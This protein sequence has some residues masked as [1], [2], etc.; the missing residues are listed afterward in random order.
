MHVLL[1]HFVIVTCI[2]IC[3]CICAC[4]IFSFCHLGVYLYL[5]LCMFHFVTGS[6]IWTAGCKA[7]APSSLSQRHWQAAKK[8]HHQQNIKIDRYL[9]RFDICFIR[10]RLTQVFSSLSFEIFHTI[11]FE[12]HTFYFPIFQ[13]KINH[14]KQNTYKCQTKRN[15]ALKKAGVWPHFEKVEL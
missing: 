13:N 11:Y 2:C 12:I 4:S 3:F 6:G 5:Y 14:T 7:A 1:C 9:Y 10:L 8:H 15:H